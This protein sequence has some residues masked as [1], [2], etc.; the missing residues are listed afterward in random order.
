M[1]IWRFIYATLAWLFVAGVIVQVFLAGV[2]LFGAGSL[3]LH[4]SFGYWI[5]LI[6]LLMLPFAWP[7]HVGRRMVWLN[8][9]LF[10][11]VLIQTSLPYAKTDMP[12]VAALHPVNALLVFW[13]GLTI[14]RGGLALA[15]ES[16]DATP[17]A[18]DPAT[19][20]A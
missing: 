2:G 20:Q 11:V 9:A 8:V 7:A 1:R 15:R 14:G 19:Q 4:R 17:A 6:P 3:D 18:S 12:L 10:V 5:E 16:A 13:L